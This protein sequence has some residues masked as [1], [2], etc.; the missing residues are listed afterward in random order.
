MSTV[1]AATQQFFGARPAPGGI[2]FRVWAPAATEMTLV[3]HDGTAA[4]R[5][6]LPC[7]ETGLFDRIVDGAAAGDRYSYRIDE[8]VERP[9]PA[10][11]FQP[12]GVHGPSQVIDPEAFEWSDSHWGGRGAGDLIVYELHVGTFSPEGTF[13]GAAA[14]LDRLRDLGVTAVELMPVADFPGGRNWGYD[15]VCLYAPSRAYGH[16]DDL[17]RLVDRAHHLGLSVM[18]DV[19]YNHLG[20]EGAYLPQF[21]PLYFTERHSTPWG[22]ALNLD[23]P[24]SE[25]VRRFLTDNARYWIRDFHFDGLRLDATHALIEEDAGAIVREIVKAARDASPRPIVIHAEDHRNLAAMVE[26]PA[27]GGWGLDG[28]WAD[29]FHHV[30]RR[31]LAG[32]EHGYFTDFQGTTQEL[33]RTIRQGWLFTGQKS[34]HQGMERGTDASRVPM[35]RFVVCLQNHD[36]I[37]NRA[38]GDRLHQSIAPEAWRAASAVLLTAPMTPLIFMGQEWSADTPFQYFTDLEPDLGRLVTAGRRLEFAAFP[39]FSDEAARDRIPDPQSVSTLAASRLNWIEADAPDHGAVLALYRALLALRLDHAALGASDETAGDAEAPDE[40]SLVI[41]RAAR[42]E[43]FWV[44]AQMKGAGS[45]DLA[46]LAE[47][48]GEPEGTWT[49]MLSTEEPLYATA[50]EPARIDSQPEGPVVHF[51]RPGAVIFRKT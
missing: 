51:T 13:A 20:P 29:D 8:G 41:R 18:L 12:D 25:M 24:G 30:M 35:R 36:Q 46:R 10:S 15:G 45:I 1:L 17:R 38:M 22:N 7:G 31:L 44:A 11:R 2:R 5:Y 39:E 16:P 19:V 33:A 40:R 23:G 4:G 9:D 3:I 28:V 43:V 14:R 32:D 47:A 37:G 6:P 21:Q 34:H 27:A 49:V 26:D 50:P 42:G 48:R